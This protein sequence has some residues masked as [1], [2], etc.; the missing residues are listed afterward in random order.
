MKKNIDK[1]IENIQLAQK[2]NNFFGELKIK[3]NQDLD[4]ISSYLACQLNGKFI[5]EYMLDHIQT[6]TKDIAE[7]LGYIRN[8]T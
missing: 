6:L 3:E 1:L 5:D 2:L 8:D 4:I 7:T